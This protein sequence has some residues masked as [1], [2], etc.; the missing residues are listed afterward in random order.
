M[1]DD[2]FICEHVTISF[3]HSLV[4]SITGLSAMTNKD[5]EKLVKHFNFHHEPISGL[6]TADLYRLLLLWDVIITAYKNYC[7]DWIT[8]LTVKANTEE[9]MTTTV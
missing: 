5:L 8:H 3:S 2:R 1:W 7:D 9:T 4:K 6:C